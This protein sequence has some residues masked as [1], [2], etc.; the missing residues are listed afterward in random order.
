MPG[1]DPAGAGPLRAAMR[2]AVGAWLVGASCRFGDGD[3]R[4]TVGEASGAMVDEKYFSL[5]LEPECDPLLWLRPKNGLVGLVFG[6]SALRDG[7]KLSDKPGLRHRE[8]F[9]VV[10]LSVSLPETDLT[11]GSLGGSS[12]AP[13][14]VRA[15]GASAPV[16]TVCAFAGVVWIVVS[17]EMPGLA[18]RSRAEVA[19]RSVG[20]PGVCGRRNVFETLL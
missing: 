2:A 20:P 16:G 4:S 11:R 8:S 5:K 19:L 13:V 14:S 6:R 10:L 9:F 18:P 12:L 15:A 7:P 1:I 17:G 3:G